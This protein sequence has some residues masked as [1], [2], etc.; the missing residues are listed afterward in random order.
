MGGTGGAGAAGGT[1]GTGGLD[2]TSASEVVDAGLAYQFARCQCPDPIS[3]VHENVCLSSAETLGFS[4]RQVECF[5][6]VAADEETLRDAFDCRIQV[7]LNSID[8]VEEVIACDEASLT[9]CDDAREVAED[10]CSEPGEA[11]KVATAPCFETTPEDAVEAAFDEY[12]ARCDCLTGCTSAD[13]PGPDVQA[14][15][16]NAVRDQAAALGEM[17]PDELAC[18]A[19]ASLAFAICFGNETTCDGG[20]LRCNAG[21]LCAISLSDARIDCASP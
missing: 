5:D 21:P 4:D 11:V 1:G 17:A 2:F 19:H 10:A 8:C 6:D 14:C 3:P 7:D 20:L 12:A 16:V 15:M 9:A 18:A 13:L